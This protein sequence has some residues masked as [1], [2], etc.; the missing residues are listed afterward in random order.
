MDQFLITIEVFDKNSR[1][2]GIFSIEIQAENRKAARAALLKH[3]PKGQI[4]FRNI[5]IT[6][7][8]KGGA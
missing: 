6:A 7:I 8:A 2:V 1:S 4:H 3:N 5:Q